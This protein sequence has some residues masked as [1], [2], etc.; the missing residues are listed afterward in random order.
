MNLQYEVG[1]YLYNI[2][3]YTASAILIIL[4]AKGLWIK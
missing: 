2:V 1:V 4:V 3:V